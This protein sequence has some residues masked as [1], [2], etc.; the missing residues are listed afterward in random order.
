M[1]RGEA[2]M[3]E[4]NPELKKCRDY[5]PSPPE[6]GRCCMR[7]TLLWDITAVWFYAANIMK[8]ITT[9]IIN[10]GY[11]HCRGPKNQKTTWSLRDFLPQLE[12]VDARIA[13][14]FSGNF[15]PFLFDRYSTVPP[16]NKQTKYLKRALFIAFAPSAQFFCS[17]SR[18]EAADV[19]VYVGGRERWELFFFF[20]GMINKLFAQR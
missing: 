19:D 6:A 11:P 4:K 5:K 18:K 13:S 12:V 1:S 16:N 15:H 3:R 8:S 20:T 7:S 10:D 9:P 2:E 17:R 14:T